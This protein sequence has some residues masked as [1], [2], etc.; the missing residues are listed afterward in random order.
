MRG[1]FGTYRTVTRKTESLSRMRI[2]IYGIGGFGRE[3]APLADDLILR[4][5]TASIDIETFSDVVFVD[6]SVDK[7]KILNGKSVISFEDLCSSFHRD[8]EV[9]VAIG[10]GRMGKRIEDKCLAAELKIGKVFAPT[11][12][13]LSDSKIGDGSIICDFTEVTSN[14]QIGKSFQ[15]NIYSYVAH[16]CV[17]GD[18]V[19]FAPRV[20][21]NGN[22]KIGDFAYIGTGAIFVQGKKGNP[23]IIGEG[24]MIGMG[25]VVTK[26]V[27]PYTLVVG[28]PAK[29]VRKLPPPI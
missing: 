9:V 18:Y 13:I 25:S 19:T 27:E 15:C 5:L 4:H 6:D 14:A 22:I 1:T 12:R 11:T 29:F 24:A 7:P 28:V 21:C 2:A 26:P 17:I 10:D 3:V 23:L 16:D 8:R 20:S